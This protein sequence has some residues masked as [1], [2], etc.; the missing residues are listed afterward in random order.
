MTSTAPRNCLRDVA[1][2]VLNTQDP[3]TKAALTQEIASHWFSGRLRGPERNSALPPDRPARPKTPTLVAPRDV[4]KRARSRP[5]VLL[6][7]VAHIELNAIDLV[8]DMIA[9]FSN[10][11]LPQAFMSD[12]VQ[13]AADEARH[14][15]LLERRLQEMGSFYGRWP[16]HDGLWEAAYA[17]RHDLT[18]RLAIVPLVLEAR[19]LD[20]TPAMI[21][22][23]RKQGDE[24]TA[25]ILETI[26]EDEIGH[27]A[28]GRRWFQY[29]CRE[30]GQTATTLFHKLVRE[31]YRG[32]IKPP[33]NESARRAAGFDPTYYLP[34]IKN[35][36]PHTTY[37]G[38]TGPKRDI[39]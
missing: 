15:T 36:A 39:L 30:K 31:F 4:P 2:H 19:G 21:L 7:A 24:A 28:A 5:D 32:Q 38:L 34:L 18:A 6:H 10:P 29:L 22:R 23:F 8:W 27:V 35:A 1:C 37:S 16:A 25:T 3:K 11:S 33:F 14:F 13:V 20:V 26:L 17:T 9:R 12:W